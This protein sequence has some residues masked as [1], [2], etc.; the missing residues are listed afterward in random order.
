MSVENAVAYYDIA[1]IMAVKIFIV[2]A[3]GFNILINFIF[4]LTVGQSELKCLSLGS[5]QCLSNF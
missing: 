3:R 2:Q 5:F 4:S 1:T